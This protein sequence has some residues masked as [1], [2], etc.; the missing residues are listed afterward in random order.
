MADQNRLDRVRNE[1]DRLMSMINKVILKMK[2][3][4]DG[5]AAG[6]SEAVLRVAKKM[7]VDAEDIKKYGLKEPFS[8]SETESVNK[9]EAVL[10]VANMM[11]VDPE[12]IK[13]YGHCEPFSGSETKLLEEGQGLN[14]AVSR[15]ADAMGNSPEDIKRFGY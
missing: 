11:G 10:C 1:A 13:K 7:G 8:E 6:I 15:I 12:D 3:P 2:R 5:S 14:D 4:P 9:D